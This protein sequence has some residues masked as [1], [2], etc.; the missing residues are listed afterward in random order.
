[1]TNYHRAGFFAFLLAASGIAAGGDEIPVGRAE[2]MACRSEI[3]AYHDSVAR[4]FSAY[5]SLICNSPRTAESEYERKY[6]EKEKAQLQQIVETDDIE[7][8]LGENRICS[9]TYGCFGP[10]MYE[11]DDVRYKRMEMEERAKGQIEGTNYRAEP[12]Q[13]KMDACISKSWLARNPESDEG[14]ATKEDSKITADAGSSSPD[15]SGSEVKS[16]PIRAAQCA[17]ALAAQDVQFNEMT[18][19]ANAAG[20]DNKASGA[21]ALYQMGMYITSQRMEVLDKYCKGEPQYATY[22]P[23]EASYKT[24]L[25][26]CRALSSDGG[27]SCKPERL[28]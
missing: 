11:S 19:K 2:A 20:P 28:W 16:D 1:M 10:H 24:A 18:R 21:R 22:A 12:V 5:V 15:A 27:G 7:W 8:W 4:S 26:G 25:D 9:S 23:T 3:S 13:D 6:C 14:D 17:E